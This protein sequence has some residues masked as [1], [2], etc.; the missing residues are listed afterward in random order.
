MKRIKKYPLISLFI[1]LCWLIYPLANY[2][3]TNA[4]A[5]AQPNQID[6][7]LAQAGKY[8]DQL[9][10]H[11]AL[12]VLIQAQQTP[13]I[14]DNQRAQAYLF[15]GVCFTAIGNTENAIQSFVETLKL[16]PNFRV[17][18]GAPPSIRS[19]FIEALKR[20]QLPLVPPPPKKTPQA[21]KNK[22]RAPVEIYAQAPLKSKKGKPINVKIEIE[23]PQKRIA[24]MAIR[25]RRIGGADYSQIKIDYKKLSEKGRKS[26]FEITIPAI[27]TEE[28]GQV[29]YYV[30][31]GDEKGTII[32][33]SGSDQEPHEVVIAKHVELAKQSSSHWGWWTAGIITGAALIAGG[34]VGVVALTQNDT[35]PA[36][37]GVTIVVE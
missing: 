35:K 17:P 14:T 37:A 11:K 36:G 4:G 21:Q 9:E 32:A 29:T 30:L 15:M 28:K 12:K 20:L 6:Q 34:I 10:Y 13:N 25:W 2:A 1:L 26:R 16:R 8:H 23:D 18:D 24:L 5:Q 7:L 3:Q 22:P 31:A 19:M 27:A 33:Q